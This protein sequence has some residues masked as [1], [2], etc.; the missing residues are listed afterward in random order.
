VDPNTPDKHGR[1]PICNAVKKG[2]LFVVIT[3]RNS[4]RVDS[5]LADND[6]LAPI[7]WARKIECSKII[8]VLQDKRENR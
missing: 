7:D 5:T 3:L 6:G 8:E 2:H 4:N 1:T